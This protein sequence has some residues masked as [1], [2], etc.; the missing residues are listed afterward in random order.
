MRLA[1][2]A[3]G[4]LLH[5]TSLP[6]PYG[7]GDLGRAAF[8][9]V[10]FLAAAGQKWWQMLPVGPIGPANSPYASPAAFAGN[11]LLLSLE[12]WVEE[13]LLSR[14]DLPESQPIGRADYDA[15]RTSRELLFRKAFRAFRPDAEF[16][17]FR[18]AGASWLDDFALYS[19]L[20]EERKLAPWFE[21][22]PDLRARRPEAL[23]RAREKLCGEIQYHLFL[24]YQFARQWA[25][26]R[27]HCAAK[28]VGLIGDVPIYM[29][30]DSVD[31]WAH[32]DLF[33]LDASGRPVRVAGVPPDYFSQ[34]GQRWGNPLYRWD[35]M[36]ERG[37]EWWIHRLRT[38]FQRFDAAR[39]DHFIGFVRCWAIPAEAPTAKEGKWLPGPGA[40]FFQSVF[41][42]LGPLEIIAE[43]LGSVTPEVHV[44]RDQF[45]LPG[46]RVLQFA[47][48]TDPDSE[49]HRPYMH[50]RHCVVY[51]G[52]H[53]NDTTVGWFND[54]GGPSSTRSP[55][56]IARERAFM[57]R[58]LA[59]EGREI[60]WDMI[61]LAFGSVADVAIVPAQDLLGLNSSARMNLPGSG[62]DNWEWRLPSETFDRESVARR[63]REMCETY[64]R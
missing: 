49:I 41:R 6:S 5:P 43:D 12:T 38:V 47:F 29:A 34:S 8:E 7:I 32:P 44:L 26:L 27:H 3:S 36:R 22:E 4:V 59:S 30:D 57:L 64:G 28:G 19:A 17:R 50:P 14:G 24:Q 52:T 31:V 11:P 48:S 54:R 1:R 60:H 58:Y 39:L 42:A 10:D 16:D 55:E 37:Y 9:F 23:A 40:A 63:L 56:D 51:T 2:R 53:D 25:A 18:T 13:G 46:M 35:V 62:Q 20:K 15:V 61:R 45:G 21:W 33:E